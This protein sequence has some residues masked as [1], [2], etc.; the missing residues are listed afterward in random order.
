[1]AL[2][3]WGSKRINRIF[4]ETAVVLGAVAIGIIA[5]QQAFKQR[6]VTSSQNC[7]ETLQR[8]DGAKEQWALDHGKKVGDQVTWNDL[9]LA[10]NGY[11]KRTP[12]CPYGGIYTIGSIGTDPKCTLEDAANK[13]HTLP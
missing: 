11:L 12:K 1:M 3:I 6:R 7:S 9:I 13:L 2:K 4:W 8:I 10:S 5:W